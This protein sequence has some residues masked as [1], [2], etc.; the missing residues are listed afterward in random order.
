MIPG[1]TFYIILPGAPCATPQGPQPPT[2]SS[3]NASFA[4]SR[5]ER[6]CR[7]VME[8]EQ[9]Q[10]RHCRFDF[11]IHQA[12]QASTCLLMFIS[13]WTPL[14]M[15]FFSPPWQ[16][17]CLI[18]EAL[19]HKDPATAHVPWA[20]GEVF[21]WDG[22]TKT[23][24]SFQKSPKILKLEPFK[25]WKHRRMWACV[26]AMLSQY[27]Q[28]LQQDTKIFWGHPR[29]IP[30]VEFV[31][32][33]AHEPRCGSRQLT[34]KLQKDLQHFLQHCFFWKIQHLSKKN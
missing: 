17:K 31:D 33:T 21:S 18:S 14:D 11:Q 2:V 30:C 25:N 27:H 5:Q 34:G 20:A 12:Y 23:S 10:N 15:R 26:T 32:H 9:Q 22:E 24:T 16:R 7:E 28:W 4:R 19:Q 8:M 1:D 13:T 29:R 6:S 3:S